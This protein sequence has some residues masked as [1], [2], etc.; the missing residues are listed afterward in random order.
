MRNVLTADE[1]YGSCGSSIQD[2]ILEPV[3]WNAM[4]YG[5]FT[6]E[7]LQPPTD[8]I[9]DHEPAGIFVASGPSFGQGEIEVDVVDVGTTIMHLHGLSVHSSVSGSVHTSIFATDL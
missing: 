6:E 4:M 8:H 7:W 2:V 5:D 3:D 1:V 9:A